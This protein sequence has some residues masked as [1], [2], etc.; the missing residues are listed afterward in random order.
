MTHD[1]EPPLDGS[2]S[3]PDRTIAPKSGT[4]RSSSEGG[5]AQDRGQ[6]QE[7]RREESPPARKEEVI[8]RQDVIPLILQDDDLLEA[9]K[10]AIA[11]AAMYDLA[12]TA[13][14]HDDLVYDDVVPYTSSWSSW[15][16][17]ADP[18][19][20]NVDTFSDYQSEDS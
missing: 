9:Q 18:R 4:R 11:A 10:G 16:D 3:A 19:L 15:E 1:N 13:G 7:T 12:H 8:E 17:L 5:S 6:L 14:A 20:K 2:S